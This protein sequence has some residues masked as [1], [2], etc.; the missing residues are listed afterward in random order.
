MPF[1]GIR[2]LFLSTALLSPSPC[3][4]NPISLDQL[5]I[6]TSF[7]QNG[8][9]IQNIQTVA[10]TFTVGLEGLLT[11]VELDLG[12]CRFGPPTADL[13]V[14]IRSTLSDG[15]PSDDVLASDTAASE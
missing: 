11:A 15:S 14:E 10:Q 7:P 13:L 6:P 9:V 1:R 2:V 12:C 5:Y 4:P 3:W 8:L